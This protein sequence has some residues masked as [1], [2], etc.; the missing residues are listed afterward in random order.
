MDGIIK[1]GNLPLDQARWH[2]HI[3]CFHI[4]LQRT[5]EPSVPVAVNHLTER[6]EIIRFF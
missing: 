5:L 2:D 1:P 4:D 3:V 6:L